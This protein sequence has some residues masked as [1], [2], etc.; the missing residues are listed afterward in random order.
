MT[1]ELKV[2]TKT[3]D[4][5]ISSRLSR[6]ATEL[7]ERATQA[8]AF[9][10]VF[11]ALRVFNEHY[12][13]SLLDAGG[14]NYLDLHT[15][16]PEKC[17]TARAANLPILLF[18]KDIMKQRN[19]WF[20]K[21]WKIDENSSVTKEVLATF[22]FSCIM[23]CCFYAPSLIIPAIVKG[24]MDVT[25]P[26]HWYQMAM[27]VATNLI[28]QSPLMTAAVFPTHDII[29]KEYGYEPPRRKKHMWGPRLYSIMSSSIQRTKEFPYLRL[30]RN[31]PKE[32]VV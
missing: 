30:E 32:V 10:G 27:K 18:A 1:L 14:V 21:V 2:E 29:M 25:N 12:L 8:Y 23:Q 24:E 26:S 6:F 19:K 17:L 7:K 13:P 3:E 16:S 4:K 9:G 5:A 28:I 22:S 15:M 20:K 11:T 31:T